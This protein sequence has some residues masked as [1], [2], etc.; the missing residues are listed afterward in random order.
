MAPESLRPEH[1]V[2]KFSYASDVYSFGVTAFELLSRDEPYPMLQAHE[3]AI[4]VLQDGLRPPRAELPPHVARSLAALLSPPH[5]R[6]AVAD[7]AALLE[8]MWDADPTKRP[9]MRDVVD[10]LSAIKGRL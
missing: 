2:T 4:A 5:I 10:R 8:C 6:S 3:A 7:L 9:S 1:G